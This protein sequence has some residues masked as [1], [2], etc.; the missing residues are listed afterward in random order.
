MLR[1]LHYQ[2]WYKDMWNYHPCLPMK[3]I[4][5]INDITDMEGNMLIW[6]CVGSA[7]IGLPFLEKEIGEQVPARLRFYGF[8][9][10]KEF[11]EECA[12][13]GITVFGVIWKAHLWEFP[14]EFNADK[15]EILSMNITRGI[16][17]KGWIGISE[18]SQD[19]YP[20]LFAPMKK[21]FPKG[22]YD[23]EGRLITDYLKG[24]KAE[25]IEGNDIFS[26]WLMMPNHEH[27]CWMPCGN[28]SAYT[29]YIKKNIEMMI[30]A[31]VGGILIDETSTQWNTFGK[32]GGC[33]CNDCIKQFRNY[34]RQNPCA[35]IKGL[36][37]ST[38]NYKKFLLKK[39]YKENNL[40]PRA[41]KNRW[42]VPLI[43]QWIAFQLT[44][45]EKNVNEYAGY[46]RKYSRKVRGKEILVTANI[47]NC[48]PLTAFYRETLD[49]I[50]GEKGSLDLRQDGWYRFAFGYARGR[51][52]CFSEC[53]GRYIFQMN[54]DIRNGNHDTYILHVLEPYAQ[55]C[56]MSVPYGAW[57]GKKKDCIYPNKQ[58]A[59]RMG[60]WLRKNE[61]FFKAEPVADI[62][63]LYDHY[64]AFEE[65]VY[66]S[67][68]TSDDTIDM[69]GF[70]NN[71]YK[72]VQLLCNEHILYRVEYVS[73]FDPLSYDR[74]KGYSRIILPD[75]YLIPE[76][77]QKAIRDWIDKKGGRALVIG[78]PPTLLNGYE[79][80]VSYNDPKVHKWLKSAAHQKITVKGSKQV[81]I[82]FHKIHNGYALHI[83]NY[84]LNINTRK[85]E[86][87]PEIDIALDWICKSVETVT[88]PEN[89]CIKVK[90]KNNKIKIKNIGIYSILHLFDGK[91]RKKD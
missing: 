24:L 16:G 76:S 63:I 60:K 53:P 19:K 28:K 39:G 62:A 34:L 82:G 33:F 40:I 30:N 73:K 9:N 37:L 79:K 83:V 50:C 49:I 32:V 75:M 80:A 12:K 65:E 45:A 48:S 85:I 86:Y 52:T 47:S 17:E 23:S 21:F 90:I 11:C 29:A 41:G 27:K 36:D 77:D 8:L 43:R 69:K 57:L 38:F 35:E 89:D 78:K 44:G 1:G 10:D 18:L 20:K 15:S 26:D 2:A 14:A 68:I 22:L 84:N 81:G 67:H 56:G 3:N 31:G 13:R 7:G 70:Y 55:G 54:E 46:I 5:M 25:S 42:Q 61:H 66:K 59:D 58:L 6:S 87:V 74:L 72:L 88:F 64:A 4:K 51:P 71:F 91:R